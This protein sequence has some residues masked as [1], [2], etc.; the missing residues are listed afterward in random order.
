MIMSKN[1]KALNDISRTY[2]TTI[3]DIFWRLLEN[4]VKCAPKELVE[5]RN[6]YAEWII[7]SID[8]SLTNH[9]VLAPN[10][11]LRCC[12][13]FKDIP[14]SETWTT[15]NFYLFDSYEHDFVIRVHEELGKSII[16]FVKHRES[17]IKNKK[18]II[19][20]IIQ[21]NKRIE[22]W[23]NACRENGRPVYED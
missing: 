18:A 14:P 10:D 17:N 3:Y 5:F 15:K 19:E 23:V 8:N 2:G 9:S 6:N 4:Y 12:A 1:T 22:L 21:D 13:I 7:S 20:A 11:I 16:D